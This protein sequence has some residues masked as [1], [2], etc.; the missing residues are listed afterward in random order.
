M[1]F[2]QLPGNDGSKLGFTSIMRTLSCLL[3]TSQTDNC[4]VAEKLQWGSGPKIVRFSATDCWKANR[5]IGSSNNKCTSI[6]R[7]SNVRLDFIWPDNL[8]A[9]VRV[10]LPA[11]ADI[12]G[13]KHKCYPDVRQN[14]PHANLCCLQYFFLSISKWVFFLI[15][16]YSGLF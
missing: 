15:I 12:I 11:D 4:N 6:K 3:P 13:I 14:V 2:N 10:S 8:T 9:R 1:L 16:Y 7:K 5:I